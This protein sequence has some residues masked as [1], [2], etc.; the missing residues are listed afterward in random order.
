MAPL[1]S[2]T[3][4]IFMAL[5]VMKIAGLWPYSWWLLSVV[6]SM[7]V[8]LYALAYTI[9][10]IMVYLKPR[11][12]TD[13]LRM[14]FYPEPFDIT[15]PAPFPPMRKASF[16]PFIGWVETRSSV[17]QSAEYYFRLNEYRISL[18]GRPP[19]G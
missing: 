7:P 10:A 8:A 16:W 5:F 19:T 13:T 2:I 15:K 4:F 17:R 18:S 1:L 12:K 3:A 9:A 6:S 11:G 14:E